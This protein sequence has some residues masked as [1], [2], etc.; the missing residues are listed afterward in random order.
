MLDEGLFAL[1]E[2][3]IFGRLN[4]ASDWEF[5]EAVDSGQGDEC[6]LA[7]WVG[8]YSLERL[9]SDSFALV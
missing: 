1:F 3:L 2:R 9:G 4:S 7:D 8:E 5:F 6:F